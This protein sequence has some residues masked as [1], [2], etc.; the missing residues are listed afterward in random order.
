L[1]APVLAIAIF[2]LPATAWAL[3]VPSFRFSLPCDVQ[4]QTTATHYYGTGANLQTAIN[5]ASRGDTLQ[6]RGTCIGNFTI[7]NT[8]LSLVGLGTLPE[9]MLNG[10]SS[11]TVV[12]VVAAQLV[13]RSSLKPVK[14]KGQLVPKLRTSSSILVARSVSKIPGRR[15]I[16]RQK[17]DVPVQYP[18]NIPRA[19]MCAPRARSRKSPVARAGSRLPPPFQ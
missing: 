6:V 2:A 14:N 16:V 19:L 13:R 11:G 15:P 17:K 12:S 9:A 1:A 8:S 4:N 10:N 3:N 18:A 7:A 5:S